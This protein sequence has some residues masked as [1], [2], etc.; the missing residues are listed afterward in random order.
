VTP[1]EL[2]KTMEF[3]VEHQAKFEVEIQKLFESQKELREADGR[4]RESQATLT[5][6]LLRVT[7]ILEDLAESQKATD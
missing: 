1:E 3:I 4:L 6:A 7:A 2:Q 5:A